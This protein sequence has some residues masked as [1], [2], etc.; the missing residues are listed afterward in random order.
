MSAAGDPLRAQLRPGAVRW[1][2]LTPAGRPGAIG[3]IAL[4]ADSAAALDDALDALGMAAATGEAPLRPLL[5]VDE[6]LVCRAAPA[7]AILTPHGGIEIIRRLAERLEQAG[8]PQAGPDAAPDVAP[9]PEATDEIEARML[10]ALAV[11]ASPLAIRLLFDQPRRW[12]ARGSGPG[13][14]AEIPPAVAARL[15]RLL[16]PPAVAIVGP[17]NVGKSALLN[18]LA[19]RAVSVV[20]DEP[21]T[22]RDHVGA[23]LD[24]A[25]LVVRVLDAPGERTGAGAIESEAQELAREVIAAA[26]LLLVCF[27]AG[28][29][30]R[31]LT[32]P[33]GPPRLRIA[34]RADLGEP[35]AEV[36]WEVDLVTSA[37]TGQG[38]DALAAAVRDALVPPADLADPRPWRFWAPRPP[39]RGGYQALDRAQ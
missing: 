28:A 7:L 4:E 22:T 33:A 39:G 35:N 37:E 1:R 23:L 5:G 31:A 16:A 11:A 34:T 12:R 6:G 36:A 8:V 15:Q 18:R 30:P 20:A 38:L 10:D 29:G 3:A 19:R 14:D 32:L 24:C 21:G 13:A 2:L 25:G 27:D 9:W 17:P 26:D